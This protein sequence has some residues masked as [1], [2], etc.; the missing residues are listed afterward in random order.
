MQEK[1]SENS[2]DRKFLLGT[3]LMLSVAIAFVAFV[4]EVLPTLGF[5]FVESIAVAIAC[6]V[7][8]IIILYKVVVWV[9]RT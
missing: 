6:Y 3:A 5:P 4:K 7:I 2:F 8:S 1:K 9:E